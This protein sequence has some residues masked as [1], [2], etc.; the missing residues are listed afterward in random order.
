L[1]NKGFFF[2]IDIE[3]KRIGEEEK[4]RRREEENAPTL[5]ALNAT[6]PQRRRDA[7]QKPPPPEPTGHRFLAAALADSHVVVGHTQFMYVLAFHPPF[8]RTTSRARSLTLGRS[9][10]ERASDLLGITVSEVGEIIGVM[11]VVASVVIV[12]WT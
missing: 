8:D 3:K 11:I 10:D 12:R 4:K 7:G 5:I 2:T 1:L 9:A 6:A